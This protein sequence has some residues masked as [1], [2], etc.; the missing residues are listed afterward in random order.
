M[1]KKPARPTDGFFFPLG[2]GM[3]S[4][5]VITLFT[6]TAD[7][8]AHIFIAVGASWIALSLVW[9]RRRITLDS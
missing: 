7:S 6:N 3:L 4:V 8:V 2:L 1:T 5:G 9:R